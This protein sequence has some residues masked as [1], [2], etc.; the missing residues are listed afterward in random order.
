MGMNLGMMNNQMDIGMMNNGMGMNP[1]MMNNQMGTGMM[2]PLQLMMNNNMANLNQQ[3]NNLRGF[4]N[5]NNNNNDQNKTE[6][7]NDENMHVFFRVGGNTGPVSST[8]KIQFKSNEKVSDLIQRYRD[9]SGDNDKTKKF[10][11]NAKSLSEE[12][13]VEQAG[14]TK[15]SNI[16]VVAM[17]GIKGA[18]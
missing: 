13:T 9:K 18:N 2:N 4:F 10:I 12:M 11:Y 5:D 6:I 16:F 14:I 8:L 7:N 15:N 1:G 17:K 3:A